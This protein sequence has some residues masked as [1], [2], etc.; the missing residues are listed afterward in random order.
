MKTR[1]KGSTGRI[2]LDSGVHYKG[3]GKAQPTCL[4]NRATSSIILR[5]AATLPVAK[6]RCIRKYRHK[7]RVNQ[8]MNRAIFGWITY[9]VNRRVSMNGLWIKIKA[10]KQLVKYKERSTNAENTPLK[11]WKIWLAFLSAVGNRENFSH[12][13][14]ELPE[15]SKPWD[16]N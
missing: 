4:P 8:N 11:F 15:T 1:W 13:V 9:W 14:K 12:M 3:Q 6:E 16:S 7:Q 10:S 2:Y 5:D